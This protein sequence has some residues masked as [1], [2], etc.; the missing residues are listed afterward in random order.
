MESHLI[1]CHQRV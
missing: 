1:L